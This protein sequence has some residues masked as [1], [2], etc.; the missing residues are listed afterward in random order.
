MNPNYNVKTAI[1]KLE[2]QFQQLQLQINDVHQVE[3]QFSSIQDVKQLLQ[4]IQQ[5][6]NTPIVI[7][8]SFS[9]T[10][11]I[12]STDH[13][14]QSQLKLSQLESYAAQIVHTMS[15][16]QTQLELLEKEMKQ[17]NTLLSS[18]PSEGSIIYQEF[19]I[20]KLYLDK[21]E[22]T[23]N[24]GQLGI[25]DLHGTLHIGASHGNIPHS[26]PMTDKQK[27][28]LEKLKQDKKRK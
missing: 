21:Y 20:D 2:A 24:L 19:N 26:E 13:I 4:Q 12:L 3:R 10:Q 28:Q 27:E 8:H 5:Q 7:H 25:K 14:E 22:L 6:L 23:N 15:L 11:P 16:V 18:S 9:N 17:L 1:S